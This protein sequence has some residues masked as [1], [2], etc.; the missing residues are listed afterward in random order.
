MEEYIPMWPRLQHP[1]G[2]FRHYKGGEYEVICIARH[3]ETEEALVVYRQLD[4]DTGFWVR[5]HAMFFE[6]IFHQGVMQP[7][8]E[9]T[10]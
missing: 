5:P 2:R 1:L 4:K 9:K 3:S 7:R 10:A 6:M 8:F